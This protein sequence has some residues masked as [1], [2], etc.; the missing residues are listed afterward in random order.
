MTKIWN[1][2]GYESGPDSHD[3]G[4]RAWYGLERGASLGGLAGANP[5]SIAV[6]HFRYWIKQ[7]PA[8]DWHTVTE[9]SF[10]DDFLTSVEKFN[11]VIGTDDD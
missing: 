9:A 10:F 11:E 8:F 7:D 1:G 3:R 4:A 6:D 2:P 5:F